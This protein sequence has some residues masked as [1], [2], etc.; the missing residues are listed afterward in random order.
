M[1]WNLLNCRGQIYYQPKQCMIKTKHCHTLKN[2][3]IKFDP[4]KMSPLWRFII[5]PASLPTGTLIGS[6]SLMTCWRLKW[7]CPTE[8][9]CFPTPCTFKVQINLA[10]L[11][12][13]VG[14]MSVIY[15][16]H[17]TTW[18]TTYLFFL[19][20]SGKEI[21]DLKGTLVR[22]ECQCVYVQPPSQAPCKQWI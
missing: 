8:Q 17:K 13:N 4:S 22:L 1:V 6:S 9:M 11:A 19:A 15:Q 16:F 3:S 12:K 2:Y 21:R 20:N 14:K 5:D 18:R 10:P 7:L